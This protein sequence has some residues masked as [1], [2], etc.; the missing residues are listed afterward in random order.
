[1]L[2]IGIQTK[3]D[4]ALFRFDPRCMSDLLLE[5]LGIEWTGINAETGESRE[6][7]LIKFNEKKMRTTCV[8]KL[9]IL[10]TRDST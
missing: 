7:F 1:M 5:L 9:G 4:K 10:N 2:C 8:I 3:G 6:I